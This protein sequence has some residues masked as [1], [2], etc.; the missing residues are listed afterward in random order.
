M[1]WNVNSVVNPMYEAKEMLRTVKKAKRDA[2][3]YG[4]TM[5]LTLPKWEGEKYQKKL[6]EWER[7]G[8]TVRL[9]PF[10]K[11]EYAFI[12]AKE[13][14]GKTWQKGT[15]HWPVIFWV[16]GKVEEEQVAEAGETPLLAGG[17]CVNTFM[18]G[19]AAKRLMTVAALGEE[20]TA[21]DTWTLRARD[22]EAR[23]QNSV[24][25]DLTYRFVYRN[26]SRGIRG[27]DPRGFSRSGTRN[28]DADFIVVDHA[29]NVLDQ[30][31]D[32]IPGQ[33]AKCPNGCGCGGQNVGCVAALHL[34]PRRRD[35]RRDRQGAEAIPS[36]SG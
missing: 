27:G 32:G 21:P 7:Q 17:S 33:E 25:Q 10:G 24:R 9:W 12:P 8:K 15:A 2:E 28:P 16:I 18:S 22:D 3:K 11:D 30:V 29:A 13:A 19:G 5:V 34:S 4:T 35:G 20:S 26:K 1:E 6:E 14:V 23:H 36:R 31:F